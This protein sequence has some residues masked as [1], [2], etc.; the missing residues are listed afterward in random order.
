MADYVEYTT[1]TDHEQPLPPPPSGS[2]RKRAPAVHDL[3]N[4]DTVQE[5]EGGFSPKRA[6]H[7]GHDG[8]ES[9]LPGRNIRRKKG[10]YSLLTLHRH[11]APPKLRPS[12]FKE[13]SMNDKPSEQPPSVFIRAPLTDRIG[14]HASD[15]DVLMGEYHD[16]AA[17]MRQGTS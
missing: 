1:F 9:P 6:K 11:H 14:A 15:L 10:K 3:T 5:E 4:E 7:L 8:G 16:G 2:K 12:K 13:G 17:G